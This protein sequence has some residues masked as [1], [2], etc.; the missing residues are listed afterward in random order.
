LIVESYSLSDLVSRKTI[1]GLHLLPN[2]ADYQA[3]IRPHKLPPSS[4]QLIEACII[5]KDRN[6]SQFT[7][8]QREQM[9]EN[10]SKIPNAQSFSNDSGIHIHPDTI[11]FKPLSESKP[12]EES[13][14]LHSM[15]LLC[16][17][18]YSSLHSMDNRVLFNSKA[19][20]ISLL[21]NNLAS[22]IHSMDTNHAQSYSSLHFMDSSAD[23]LVIHNMEVPVEYSTKKKNTL[24]HLT[25]P[26]G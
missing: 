15:E 26:Y 12:L 18:L 20:L 3:S 5:T 9:Q 14:S 17:P 8:A 16:V 23:D 24:F 22:R 7:R 25:M 11:V 6:G 1:I 4:D 21:D 2:R 13:D 19:Q 10:D